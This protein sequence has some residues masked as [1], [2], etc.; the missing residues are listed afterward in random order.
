MR[1]LGRYRESA[2]LFDSISRF[3]VVGAESLAVLSGRVWSLTH[4]AGVLAAAG[5]T[6]RLGALADTI[7]TYGAA[8]NLGRDNRLHHHVR[9]LLLAARGQDSAAV[10]EFRRA[11]FSMATRLHANERRDGEGAACASGVMP[12]RLRF[13]SR[14]FEVRSRPRISTRRIR[15]IRL[16]L[17]TAYAGAGRRDRANQELEWVRRAWAKA[18]ADGARVRRCELEAAETA[19][20]RDVRQQKAAGVTVP[21]GFVLLSLH[22]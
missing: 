16:L 1:E 2:A 13:S 3:S 10:T 20:S 6:S 19:S 14:R 21:G 12:T 22:L 7:E 17:A 5:D 9:G 18:T 8:S 4:E 15:E 11:V